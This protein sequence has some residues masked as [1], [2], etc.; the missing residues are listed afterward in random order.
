MQP[1]KLKIMLV[2]DEECIRDSLTWFLEDLGCEV[3]D[4]LA[5]FN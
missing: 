1:I 2:E 3:I 4:G 5:Q